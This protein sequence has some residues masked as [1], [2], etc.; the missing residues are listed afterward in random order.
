MNLRGC[1]AALATL[2]PAAGKYAF[3][4]K[5]FGRYRERWEQRKGG[6][7]SIKV[8]KPASVVRLSGVYRTTESAWSYWLE[9]SDWPRDYNVLW[10][11]Q[12]GSLWGGAE[13]CCE[14]R[15]MPSNKGTRSGACANS[16][17]AWLSAVQFSSFAW[18]G[19]CVGD[20]RET[21]RIVLAWTCALVPLRA[22]RV[23]IV[24]SCKRIS[25]AQR[26][27]PPGQV[28]LGGHRKGRNNVAIQ[29]LR[30]AADMKTLGY[31]CPYI[32]LRP[33]EPTRAH[34]QND[35]DP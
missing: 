20:Y 3:K 8:P 31:K 11:A 29:A 22:Y 7:L 30:P 35:Y 15:G 26:R 34:D 4:R 27:G 24:N 21:R 23:A 13:G 12:D 32:H 14:S 5:S 9:D 10:L 16:R 33:A 28:P 6:K 2:L 25:F 17:L 19:G 1:R 18:I